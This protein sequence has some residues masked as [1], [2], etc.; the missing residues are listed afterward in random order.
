MPSTISVFNLSR[1]SSGWNAR[2]TTT[3]KVYDSKAKEGL[4]TAILTGEGGKYIKRRKNTWTVF[5]EVPQRILD[6]RAGRMKEA[7]PEPEA[8]TVDADA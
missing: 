2:S 6:R 1:T 7:A 5:E 3:N 8:I 4:Y